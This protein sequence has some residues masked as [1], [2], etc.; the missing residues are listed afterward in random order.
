[1]CK[2]VELTII[3][4]DGKETGKVPLLN[5]IGIE[6]MIADFEEFCIWASVPIDNCTGR[7]GGGLSPKRSDPNRSNN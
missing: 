6:R 1:M 4:P 5:R 2:S 3:P 7:P